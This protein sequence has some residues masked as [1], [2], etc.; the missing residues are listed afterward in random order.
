MTRWDKKKASLEGSV[1]S[2]THSVTWRHRF[3]ERRSTRLGAYFLGLLLFI[4]LFADFLAADLP[5]LSSYRG[6]LYILPNF[7]RPKDLQPYDNHSLRQLFKKDDWALWPPVPYGPEQT[8]A[9]HRLNSLSP[10]SSHHLVGTDAAGRDVLAQIIHGVRPALI[11]GLLAVLLSVFIGTVLGALSGYFSGFTDS[12]VTWAMA[13]TLT[14]PALLL[15]LTFSSFSLTRTSWGLGLLLGIIGWAP[16][17]RLIRGQVRR[18]REMPYVL[19]A[20]ASGAGHCRIL[21]LHVMPNAA[22]PLVVMAA[23]GVGWAVLMESA[24][25]F[26][27]AGH[28]GASWGRLL[29]SSRSTP[30]AW[31]LTLFSGVC[32]FS[33]VLACNLMAEGLRRSLNPKSQI[34][35]SG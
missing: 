15:V 16:V 13:V 5:L 9:A 19:A 8:Q 32:L 31:W 27:G 22:E 34:P 20:R 21:T 1:L 33:T 28:H 24:L 7:T 6:K 18:I 2:G 35:W 12:V 17:A 23:F 29:A 11:V 14:F 10:P 26:L 30:D 25:S 3:W 4:G